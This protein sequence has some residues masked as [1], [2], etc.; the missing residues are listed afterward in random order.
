MRLLV[1]CIVIL[2]F[3]TYSRAQFADAGTGA[4]RQKIWWFDWNGFSPVNGASKT[5]TTSEGLTV[6]IK[7]SNVTGEV[8]FPNVMNTWSGAVLHVL[9]NFQ[10]SQI[11]P[12]LQSNQNTQSSHLTFNITATRN[13]V[14]TPFTFIIADAE[15]SSVDEL[16]K[17]HTTGSPWRTLEFYR[18]SGQT[19]NP[20]AGCNTPNIIISDTYGNA[21]V[22]GQNPI[23]ATDAD[24]SGKLDIDVTLEKKVFGGM[25]IAMGIFAPTDR[26]DLPA[27]YGYVQHALT[28]TS[29]N[30]CNYQNPLPSLA[31]SQAIKL[32]VVAGDSD[33]Q[34]TNDDGFDEDGI[35]SFPP[36][37]GSGIYSIDIQLSNT[38]SQNTFLSGW[39]DY[40]NDGNFNVNEKASATVVPGSTLVKMIWNNIPAT[41]P[42]AQ[43]FA[44]RFRHSSNAI[45]IQSPNGYAPDGE[46]ED[47]LTALTCNL[48]L[49][50]SSDASLCEGKQLQLNVT[51]ADTYS[52]SPSTGLSADNVSNPTLQASQ[53]IS[54]VITGLKGACKGTDTINISVTP[55]PIIAVNPGSATA[56]KNDQVKFTASGG[57]TYEWLNSANVPVASSSAFTV[58]AL[59]S[60]SY[61]AVIKSSVCQTTDTIPVLLTVNA[62]PV[63]TVT[64][65]ND[66]D[67]SANNTTLTA[68]GGVNY[69]WTPSGNI[70]NDAVRN[71]IVSPKES[72]TY[73]V[74]VTDGNGCSAKDSVLVNVD[75]TKGKANYLMPSAFTPNGDGKNDCFGLK[76]NAGVADFD[77]SIYDRTGVL[78]FRTADASRCW[79]GTYKSN[80]LPGGTYVYQMKV[81]GTCNTGYV[82]GTVVLIR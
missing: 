10:N 72:T 47:Y 66:I 36:Y 62:L 75:F 51:G 46:I 25:A 64:K 55:K 60:T 15:A 58:T 41:L 27:S 14:P 7:C 57:D 21:P 6:T 52:W 70:S 2:S 65:M 12:A 3:H 33:G 1:L 79:D 31:Q 42:S 56:C 32:G 50:G 40:N 48:K 73:T 80:L 13:G 8:L 38:T 9:Y 18:N 4:L 44:F 37:D 17:V 78:L 5:F 22:R 59:F 39:F 81:S 34:E 45:F 76:Y 16:T 74:T 28:F 11:K 53:T 67:C 20:V 71:P 68:S 61:N 23:E 63:A 49:S 35:G 43:K 29:M 24:A 26:G 77:L 30:E 19:T 82:K 54:Y 69:K